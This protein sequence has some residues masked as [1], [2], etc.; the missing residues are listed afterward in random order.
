MRLALGTLTTALIVGP[1]LVSPADAFVRSKTASGVPIE[2]TTNCISYYLN[3]IGSEDVAIDKVEAAIIDSFGAW[4]APDCSD[5]NLTYAGRT[6]DA[7]AGYRRSGTNRNVVVWRDDEGSWVHQSS[8]IAVTTVTFCTE[9][10]SGCPFVGAIL[11]AD[12][13]LN[14]EGFR[15]TDTPVLAATRFDIRNTVTHEAGHF[16]GLDHSANT[17]ATMFASAPPGERSKATLHEDDVEGIC[18]IYP[19]RADGEVCIATAGSAAGDDV[20]ACSQTPGR[21]PGAP[22][23]AG[24]LALMGIARV[25]RRRRQ[26]PVRR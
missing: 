15:F 3:E 25:A 26:R 8:I 12:I 5:L 1:A 21:G 13:E 2:W 18:S 4:E 24:L 23:F 11:D 10:G 20:E 16:F 14:G 7:S 6:N 17:Q 19:R 22:A 9:A